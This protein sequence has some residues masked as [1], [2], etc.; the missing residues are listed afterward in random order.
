MR[1][2]WPIL[3]LA[4]LGLSVGA[5][6]SRERQGGVTVDQVGVLLQPGQRLML[7]GARAGSPA[8]IAGLRRGD[9]IVGVN[10]RLVRNSGDLAQRLRTARAQRITLQIERQ[11]VITEVFFS[12]N[13]AELEQLRTRQT[14][15]RRCVT[16]CRG[17]FSRDWNECGCSVVDTKICNACAVGD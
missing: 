16:L 5:A 8:E 4:L 14:A 10:R 7:S 11:D 17:R 15:P 12:L 13:P 3:L 6:A 2:Y 1:S 9:R